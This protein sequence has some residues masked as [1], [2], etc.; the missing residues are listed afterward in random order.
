MFSTYDRVFYA[1]LAPIAA[2][3]LVVALFVEPLDGDLT[4]TG[5]FLE[6]RFGWQ[7]EQRFFED[8]YLFRMADSIA[9]ADQ[10]FDVVV[11]GDSFT[12]RYQFSWAS[13]LAEMTGWR[14][15]GFHHGQVD[16]QA[17]ISSGGLTTTRPVMVVY[18][19][20]ER[21]AV[22]RFVEMQDLH[23]QEAVQAWDRGPLS[24]EPRVAASHLETRSTEFPSVNERLSV[25]VHY[26][27]VWGR[28]AISGAHHARA[29]ALRA[30]TPALF[31][32]ADQDHVLLL[33]DDFTLRRR[34]PRDV[35]AAVEGMRN[36]QRIVE[37][38]GATFVPLIF[39]DK[40]TVYAP[41]LADAQ[42]RGSSVIPQLA[43]AVA[44]PRLDQAYAEAVSSLMVD[45]Y[46]PNNTHTSP[47]GSELAAEV[48]LH[49]AVERGLAEGQSPQTS[50]AGS[51]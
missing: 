16:L 28:E 30:D 7:D 9:E 24:L 37:G 41:Y 38:M 51:R 17:L 45:V 2:T 6:S 23:G 36:A 21:H 26:L 33:E 27:R 15:L 50:A 11:L 13:Y 14:I 44:M 5:G 20:V 10:P 35:P 39:P 43:E 25:A 1:L 31:S 40:L 46:A 47:A 32:S 12:R 8:G 42:W 4:R 49:F 22:R 34:A 3:V 19:T 48:F 18:Q 29:V